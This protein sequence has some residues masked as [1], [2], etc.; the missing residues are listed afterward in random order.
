MPVY[1]PLSHTGLGCHACAR[2]RGVPLTVASLSEPA[3]LTGAAALGAASKSRAG[4]NRDTIPPAPAAMQAGAAARASCGAG[5]A[6]VDR[7]GM[8][9]CRTY[10]A[11]TCNLNS[12]QPQITALGDGH[13]LI[14]TELLL[15]QAPARTEDVADRSLQGSAGRGAHACAAPCRAPPRR[16]APAAACARAP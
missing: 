9:S 2:V 11:S 15:L 6:T 12:E 3:G 16:V 8:S 1:P 4:P 7:L 10:P 13:I 5:G 14:N